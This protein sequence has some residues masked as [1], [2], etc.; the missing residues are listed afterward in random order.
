MVIDH[1]IEDQRLHPLRLEHLQVGRLYALVVGVID[2]ILVRFF[3]TLQVIGQGGIFLLAGRAID[4]LVLHLVVE[5]VLAHHA[6][7]DE[8]V[9]VFPYRLKGFAIFLR[10]LDH[11]G[12]NPTTDDLTDLAYLGLVLQITARN[13]ER[14][15]RRIETAL[16]RRKELRDQLRGVVGDEHLIAEQ[17][18][19]ALG[20]IELV[21]QA[22]EIDNPFEV[23]GKI[24]VEMNPEQ[25][26]L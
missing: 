18:D 25:R 13:I 22:R 2:F 8:G 7:L 3:G 17:L 10:Q 12:G 20:D 26:I 19:V 23:E 15:V 9:D 5:L 24:D 1:G 21:G 6:V 14:Q 16:Q 11:L 4:H